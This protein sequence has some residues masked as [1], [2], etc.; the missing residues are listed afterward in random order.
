MGLLVTLHEGS[1]AAAARAMVRVV[2]RG[3]VLKYGCCRDDM[4]FGMVVVVATR[5]MVGLL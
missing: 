5:A 1:N 4:F 2:R 3:C